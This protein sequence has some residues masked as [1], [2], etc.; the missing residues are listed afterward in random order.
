MALTDN[1]DNDQNGAIDTGES[2]QPAP[3]APFSTDNL[4]RGAIPT[5]E[6]AGLN[7]SA[8]QAPQQAETSPTSHLLT[9]AQNTPPIQALRGGVKRIVGYLMGDGAAN[10]AAIEQAGAQV[11]PQGQLSA[12]DRNLIA[13][14]RAVELAGPEAGWPLMQ[15]H[16]VAYNAKQAFAKTALTGTQQ[17]PADLNAAIDAA[18]QAGQHVLD[19]SSVKFSPAQGG[20]TATVTMPGTSQTQQIPLTAE[21]FGKY[22]D[23]GKDGQWDKVMDKSVPATLAA[24]QKETPDARA[25]RTGQPQATDV[26]Q[27]DQPAAPG[28]YDARG[29]Y[30]GPP[31]PGDKTNYGEELEARADAKF[32]RGQVVAPERQD[33]LAGQEEKELERQ[34][35]IDVAAETGKNR[36]EA[37]RQTGAGRVGAAEA[38]SKGRVEAAKVGG[39][40]KLQGW[41]YASQAKLDAAKAQIA[42]KLQQQEST[43][44]NAAQ[45]RALKAIQ[46]KIMS[47][48]PLTP[49]EQ[50]FMD[51]LPGAAQQSAPVT[52]PRQTGQQVPPVPQV[53][54]PQ[55]PTPGAQPAKQLSAH[56]QQAKA[57]ANANPNDPRAAQI[58]QKLG[59]Q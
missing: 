54:A 56:D 32:G 21:Q 46:T 31:L 53:G 17:K 49:K 50:S 30:I 19:G 38:I 33:W 10:P 26:T 35:S 9:D 20:V 1:D 22:L 45:T 36:I 43:N 6:S 5:D 18:N 34:K 59:A 44:A 2:W 40:L 29:H 7:T 15:A 58:L 55:A 27:A 16:R 14:N 37:A 52:S 51:T 28:M 12:D 8:P 47:A 23:I 25:V 24:I 4:D 48:Q 11:D 13:L 3:S 42:A 39:E 41:Q 57:W